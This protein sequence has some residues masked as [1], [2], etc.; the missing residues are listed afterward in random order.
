VTTSRGER[1]FVLA[2]VLVATVAAGC[3]SSK[4]STVGTVASGQLPGAEIPAGGS[5]AGDSKSAGSTVPLAKQNP[6]TTLFA[7]IKSFQ[8]CLTGLG[9]TFIGAPNPSDPSSG[10]NNPAYIK[11]LT[12]CAAR[13][14]ILQALKAEQSAQDNLTQAQIKKENQEYLLFRT[15]MIAD[16]WGIPAPKPNASG[17]LFSFGTTGGDAAGFT[18]PPGQ[19]LLSSSDLQN[20]AAKAQSGRS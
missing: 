14:N 8:S 7:S 20:C 9:V 18:P 3:G 16:G 19:T 10:A 13:S 2:I 12:T 15:C 4:A 11:S 5:N 1:G 6:I 17:L